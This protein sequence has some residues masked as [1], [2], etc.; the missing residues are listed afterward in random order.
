MTTLLCFDMDNT[1]VKATKAHLNAYKIAFKQLKLPKK[2]NKEIFEYFS[3]ASAE[4]VKKL[5]PQLSKKEINQVVN[6]HNNIFTKKTVK[7]IKIIPGARETLIRLA[8]F[9]KIAILSNATHRHI[10]ET[11]KQVKINE[12]LFDLILGADEIK[13]SK[14]Q[15]DGI[16]KAKKI[17]KCDKGYM[18]GDAI[19]DI[20]AGRA[21]KFKTIAVLTG[22]DSKAKLKKEHPTLILRSVKYVCKYL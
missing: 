17:L 12:H 1:L 9:Y 13:H 2:T 18:I 6:I 4:F 14:P 21:A 5:Y 10:D 3:L 15:P 11:L 20:R 7:Q 8:P 22:N 19:F 16:L